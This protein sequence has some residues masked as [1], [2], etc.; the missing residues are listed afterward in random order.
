MD[1]VTISAALAVVG[2]GTSLFGMFSQSHV[3]SQVAGVSVSKAETEGQENDVRQSA[4]EMSGRRSQMEALRTAQRARAQAVQA[5][6]NQGAQYG[7]GETAGAQHTTAEGDYGL[8]GIQGQLGF[9][10]QLFGLDKQITADNI[11]LAQL[12]GQEATD[13][14]ISSLGQG[15]TKAAGPLGNIFGGGKSS[16]AGS[17]SF[18]PFNVTGSLY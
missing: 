14:G 17:S 1:P 7:T 16:N 12:K 13:Q 15:I 9:G 10:R 6:T 4:M 5:G 2:V 8:Q 18:N 11:Q 3:A